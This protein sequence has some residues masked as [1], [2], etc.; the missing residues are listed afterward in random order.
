MQKDDDIRILIADDTDLIR[1]SVIST[2]REIGF[3]NVSETKDGVQA[4]S[5]LKKNKYDLLM[6]DLNMPHWE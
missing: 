3:T 1:K 6:S 4:L 5:E 2:L